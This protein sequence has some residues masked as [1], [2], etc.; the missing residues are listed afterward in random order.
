MEDSVDAN[1][2]EDCSSRSPQ[3]RE[4]SPI[5]TALSGALLTALYGVWTLFSLPGS[6]KIPI[7]LKVPYLPS[8]TA[9]VMNAM[10]LLEG[11]SGQLVDLGSGDGRLVFAA[12]SAGFQCTGYEINSVL[13]AYARGKARMT[14]V[15]SSQATFVNKDFWKTDLSKYHNVIVFLA[16]GVMEVLGEKILREL[17]GDARVIACRFPFPQWPPR[18]SLGHGLDRAWAYDIHTV[19]SHLDRAGKAGAP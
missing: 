4:G 15:P 16:P 18:A 2:Q 3:N 6:R 17:S 10:K 13:L 5:L 12:S 14:G 7:C 11:R 9:Q 8:S 19:R 1:I